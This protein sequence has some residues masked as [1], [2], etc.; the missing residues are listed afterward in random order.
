MKMKLLGLTA[1][2]SFGV[3]AGTALADPLSAVYGNTMR[4][5]TAEGEIVNFYFNEDKSF[6]TTGALVMSG[7]WTLEGMTFCTLVD[8]ET[9]CNEIEERQ[10]GDEWVE[11]DNAG[12]TRKVTLVEGRE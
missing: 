1:A 7:T 10:I 4:V 9:N 12:G 11:D 6:E 5:Q 2:L 3:M 8:G